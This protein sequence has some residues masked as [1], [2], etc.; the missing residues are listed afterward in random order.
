M[1]GFFEQMHVRKKKSTYN[2][3]MEQI[4][5]ASARVEKNNFS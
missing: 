2:L 4:L 5:T 3:L 1:R